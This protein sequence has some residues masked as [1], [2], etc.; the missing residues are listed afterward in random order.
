MSYHESIKPVLATAFLALYLPVPFYLV[1]LHG[2]LRLWR[3]LGSAAYVFLLTPYA[4]MVLAIIHW[5]TVWQWRAWPW[6]H[7]LPWLAPVP[8]AAGGWL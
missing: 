1:W 4:A 2:L 3:R 8:L 5:H 6:P 7:V